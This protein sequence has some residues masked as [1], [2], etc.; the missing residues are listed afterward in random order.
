MSFAPQTPYQPYA[1]VHKEPKGPGDSR[2]TALRIVKDC[3]AAG[4]LKG[5]TALI[6]GT[7]SGIGVETARALYETGVTLFLTA[8]DMPK[9]EKVIEDVVSKSSAKDIP[10]PQAIE[11]H[12][13]SLES[14]R[15]G[16]E[17]FKKRANGQLNLLICNAG[18]M[19]SP[20]TKTT[21]GLELQIG[22]NHFAHFL[23]FQIV[24]PLLLQSAAESGISSRVITVS[25]LGHQFGH[26]NF[27][28]IHYKNGYDK[29]T[30]YGQSKMAN[31]YMAISIEQHYG[32]RN[33]HGLSVH[34]GGIMTE[35]GRHLD[36]S[37]WKTIGVDKV[38]HVFKTPEQGAAT[39]VWAAVSPHFEGK[40][41]GRYLGDVGEEGAVEAPAI[42]GSIEGA[43]SM[44]GYSKNA[45]DDEAAGKLW[46]L[47]YDILGLPAED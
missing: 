3:N 2:P 21:D 31:I 44:S 16:A 32:S 17:E 45:Y 40:N 23:L 19:A 25:S 39:T 27:D 1:D 24:K 36:D 42:L 6:T 8:R 9:L 15:Q 29:W 30:A 18:V 33:L 11:I 20:Y 28:D 34:P 35:L 38:G 4:T 37:D 43:T 7:S 13:D 14:V 47:S 12:L 22:T 10:R 41:G 5:K 46:K 26:G